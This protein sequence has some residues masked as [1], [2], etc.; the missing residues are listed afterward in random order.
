MARRDGLLSPE[1]FDDLETMAEILYEMA[2]K[3][4]ADILDD[5]ETRWRLEEAVERSKA[6]ERAHGRPFSRR[7]ANA[8]L[9]R[10]EPSNSCTN[11]GKAGGLTLPEQVDS[12]NGCFG[13]LA[14]CYLGGGPVRQPAAQYRTPGMGAERRK[15]VVEGG[16]RPI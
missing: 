7:A 8:R 11:S 12:K 2:E 6:R 10:G 1:V 13:A 14:L 9:G 5:E 4:H 15:S 3:P 16:V